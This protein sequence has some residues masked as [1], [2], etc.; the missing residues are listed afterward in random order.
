MRIALVWILFGAALQ[1]QSMRPEDLATG[2]LLVT[3]R[4]APDPNFT[5]SV[6][7]LVQYNKDGA[8]GLMINHRTTVAISTA[9]PELKG[10]GKRTDPMFIGGP[11][12]H[13][14]VMA[15][16]RSNAPLA[17]AEHIFEKLYLSAGRAGI[18]QAL[19]TGKT[20]AELHLYAGY[21]GWASGQLEREVKLGG[22]RIFD[23]NP[24]MVFDANPGTLWTRLIEKTDLRS[25]ENW[26]YSLERG[27][28]LGR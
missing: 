9:L 17:E 25:V 16:T 14:G 11:V 5:E 26:D 13:D 21:C 10:A 3:P 15:L 7:V 4:E 28:A 24:D 27:L 18:E 23:R 20:S 12:Q 6:I 1:A 19:A 2:K 22:W 8:V